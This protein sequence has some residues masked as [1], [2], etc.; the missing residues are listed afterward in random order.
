MAPL[1]VIVDSHNLARGLEAVGHVLVR[2]AVD[3]TTL[4]TLAVSKFTSRIL[5][6]QVDSLFRRTVR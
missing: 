1:P 6:M 3:H 5:P 4:E 2:R